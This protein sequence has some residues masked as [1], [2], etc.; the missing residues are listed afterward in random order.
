MVLWG[1]LTRWV[2]YPTADRTSATT[3]DEWVAPLVL[4]GELTRWVFYPTADRTSATTSD[5]WVAPLV[6]WGETYR[7]I[8]T[9]SHNSPKRGFPTSKRGFFYSHQKVTHFGVNHT[10][11]V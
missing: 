9:E 8:C 3:S 4:W 7:Y 10:S 11:N 2:F 6:L 5:E 1:E